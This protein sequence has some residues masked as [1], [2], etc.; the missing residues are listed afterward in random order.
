MAFRHVWEPKLPW[1]R[2]ACPVPRL[3]VPQSSAVLPRRRG[4]LLKV[5]LPQIA[6][7]FDARW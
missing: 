6:T 7:G 5:P 4:A 1:C 2:T 3:P